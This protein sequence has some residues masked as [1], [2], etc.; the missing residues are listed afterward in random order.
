MSNAN[1]AARIN[2]HLSRRAKLQGGPLPG[3]I[4]THLRRAEQAVFSHFQ[5]VL[6]DV[7][8][9]PGE[10]GVLLLIL[11]NDGLSQTELGLAIGADRSSV[12]TLIDRF[13]HNNIVIRHPSPVDRRTHA[14]SLTS[15]GS[16]MMQRLIPRIQAH[17]RTIAR[18]LSPGEQQQLIELL[19]R[20]AP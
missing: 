19:S 17:E 2:P 13:E 10:F 4:G 20:I 5:K 14:L 3:L 9:T 11:E 16:Q 12:V 7:G 15:A 8:L 6:Q 18:L 1:S